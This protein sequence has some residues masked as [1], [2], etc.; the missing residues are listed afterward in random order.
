MNQYLILMKEGIDSFGAYTP[1]IEGCIAVAKTEKDVITLIRE[2]VQLKLD[3]LIQSRKQLPSPSTSFTAPHK[4]EE[5]L[6]EMFLSID[7]NWKPKPRKVGVIYF[8]PSDEED[9]EIKEFLR[10]IEEERRG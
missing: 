4:T 7:P 5:E 9:R 2:K 1:D 6:N 3:F 8:I 10:E